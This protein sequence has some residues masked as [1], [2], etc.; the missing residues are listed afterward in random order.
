MKKRI[1]FCSF[2]KKELEGQKLKIYPG[3]LGKKI[4]NEIS[5]KAW[6]KWI[7][8]QTKLINELKLNML[9]EEDQKKI[10]KKMKIFFFKKNK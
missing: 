10:I 9:L 3:K 4:Y 1:I 8:I 7:L 6:K 5:E 2:F